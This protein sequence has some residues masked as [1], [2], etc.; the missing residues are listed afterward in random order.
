MGVYH[1]FSYGTL[2]NDTLSLTGSSLPSGYHYAL[3]ASTSGST[4]Y[5]DLDVSPLTTAYTFNVTSGN[6]GD[7][8]SWSP[9]TG[10]PTVIDTATFN[11]G[12]NPTVTISGAQAVQGVTLSGSGTLTAN[13]TS[14]GSLAITN[15]VTIRRQ[16]GAQG[17]GRDF[18][19]DVHAQW[20]A[21]GLAAPGGRR[22]LG[23]R[24]D[25][26]GRFDDA[27]DHGQ[28]E[29]GCQLGDGLPACRPDGQQ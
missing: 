16:S 11:L 5:L 19:P 9:S 1:L 13:S 24:D 17:H 26:A 21:V 6:W 25:H 14:G 4:N 7:T 2:A 27:D 3:G 20:H 22:Q 18:R 8:S 12:S 10:Y 23:W 29:P 15:P 28:P